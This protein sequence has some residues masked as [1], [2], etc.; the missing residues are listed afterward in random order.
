MNDTTEQL[1]LADEGTLTYEV[2]DE[3]L[4]AAADPTKPLFVDVPYHVMWWC[5]L[6]VVTSP[7]TAG[8]RLR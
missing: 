7:S 8:A 2:A 1:D 4:E 6:S 3:Q 5:R